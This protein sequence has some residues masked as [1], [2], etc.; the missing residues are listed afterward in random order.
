MILDYIAQ[1]IVVLGVS[2]YI[3]FALVPHESIVFP[4]KKLHIVLMLVPF[5][6]LAFC[7]YTAEN[8]REE[9]TNDLNVMCCR[10]T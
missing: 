5:F 3:M 1:Y 7:W 9:S 10:D 2:V 8:P 6:W 4:R